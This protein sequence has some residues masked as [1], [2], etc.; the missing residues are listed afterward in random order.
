M[1]P[2]FTQRMS[3][4]QDRAQV[5]MVQVRTLGRL[6]LAL[7]IVG[8][9]ATLAWAFFYTRALWNSRY[10]KDKRDRLNAINDLWLGTRSG[11]LFTLLAH[12]AFT[13]VLLVLSPLLGTVA[14][15]AIEYMRFQG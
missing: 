1:F 9:L 14:A 3:S 15:A 8:T 5:V 4:Y 7:R 11:V 6:Y 2:V 13:I 12:W 10:D